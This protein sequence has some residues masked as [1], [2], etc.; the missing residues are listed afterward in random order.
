MCFDYLVVHVALKLTEIN[1]FEVTSKL[2][3]F[4][5]P[6]PES[7]ANNTARPRNPDFFQRSLKFKS[8]QRSNGRHE[9][10]EPTCQNIRLDVKN[11]AHVELA[12][13]DTHKRIY[14]N[15]ELPPPPKKK[16]LFLWGGVASPCEIMP[17]HVSY[18]SCCFESP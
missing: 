4:A 7:T 5:P 13:Y 1:V 10:H 2:D 14:S 3:T 16:G 17:R 11:S 15:F 12:S 9:T 8:P 18:T 6:C